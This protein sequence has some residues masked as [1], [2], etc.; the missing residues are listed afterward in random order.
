MTKATLSINGT[1]LEIEGTNVTIR[2][3][4]KSAAAEIPIT[5]KRKP[6]KTKYKP[7]IEKASS[8]LN[9]TKCGSPAV[10]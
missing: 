1:E 7:G 6:Y 4:D 3:F 9:C 5:K 10:Y 2:F 8:E